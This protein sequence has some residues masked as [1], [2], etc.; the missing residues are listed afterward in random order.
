MRARL[1]LVA[2]TAVVYGGLAIAQGGAKHLNPMIELHQQ[3]KP[4][5]G[6]Y[7]PANSRSNQGAPQVGTPKTPPELAKAALGYDK[8]DFLFNG[9]MEGGV[10]RG[11]SL[12][13]DFVNAV[14]EAA[15]ADV[16]WRH[17]L[18]VKTPRIAPDPAKAVENISRQLNMGVST[19]VFVGVESADEVK[20]GLAAMRFK[21]R[22][23]TRPDDAGIAPKYWG[24]SEQAYRDK[25]DVWP[26]NPAGELTNWTIVESK[27][28]LA[29]VR[30]IAAVKGIS[31]LFPGAGTLRG[32]FTTTDADG[33]RTFDAD[34]WEKAI[35][36]VLAA[37]KEFDVPCG[38]PA[39]E[40]D[41]E[42]RIQQGFSVFIMNW[43]DPGFRAV[44]I[45]RRV[46]TAP[47]AK[48][49]NDPVDPFRIAGNL[50]Y[51]GSSDIS[52]YLIAT[53]AGHVVIDA[54]YESTVPIVEKNI[55]ALG[56]KLE[57]VK[58]LLNTQAHYDHA[59]GFAQLKKDTG[60]QLMVSG[61]DA[62]VIERGGLRDFSFGDAHPF[63]AAHVDR[64]LKNGD[65]VTLGKLTLEANVTPGHTMGC[66]TWSFDVQD[67]NKPLHVVDMC[68]LTVLD[69]TRL[70]GNAAYPA[71]VSDYERTFT[72]MRKLPVD[73]FIGAHPSYYGGAGEEAG[74]E[75]A[76]PGGDPVVRAPG[77]Q[78]HIDPGEETL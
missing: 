34:G 61:P 55:R 22:G 29:H 4:L 23:G 40:T 72:A 19:I 64:R 18:V 21:S 53:P 16:R 10:D 77:A 65:T 30:E 67:N 13:T 27:E 59:A 78:P 50:Y 70:V 44:D 28:G 38:Y 57:D 54:G 26:L 75:G 74:L 56:F 43:G 11:I 51:V 15:P 17:P 12:F 48:S 31:V 68:G 76:A 69:T 36:Q 2:C 37:C 49:D 9:S 24:L 20:Q 47:Q 1:V 32:V 35:Q 71:I 60:A 66:T 33:K 39:T 7:A 63:P 73:I 46:T 8:S 14:A 41:I 45:G 52:S 62:D 58:I 3:K 42:T 5:I 6:L 25:A